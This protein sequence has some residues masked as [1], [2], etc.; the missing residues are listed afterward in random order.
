MGD[1]EHDLLQ[2]PLIGVRTAG[3]QAQ[4]RT[5]PGVLADLG[6]DDLV[7]FSGLQRHQEQAWHAFLVQLAAIALHEADAPPGALSEAKWR[8]LLLGLTGG[9]HEPWSLVVGDLAQPALL[10]PPV[11]G[12][13]LASFRWTT[14]CPDSLDILVTAKNHDV[15]AERMA[16]PEPQHWLYALVSL[17]TMQGFLGAG[18]YGIARMNGGFASRPSVG[19]APTLAWGPRFRRDVTVLR[20]G[21]AEIAQEYGYSQH[22]GHALLW[23]EPWDG[24]QALPLAA[25][26]PFFV[27]ICRRVRLIRA[28]ERIVARAAGSSVARLAASEAKGNTGDPWTPV[29]KSEGKALSVGAAGF[30]YQRVQELLFGGEYREGIAQ[31]LDPQ[32]GEEPLFLAAVLARSQ[33]KTLGLHS[34]Q[35]PIPAHVRPRLGRPAERERLSLLARQRI[36]VVAT[37][38]KKV[39]RPSLLVLFQ[40]HAGDLKMSDERPQPW[41]RRF[42]AAVDAVFF[43]RLWQDVDEDPE[44]A[45]RRWAQLVCEFAQAE[46][47]AAI[48]SA[49]LSTANRLRAVALAEGRFFGARY[50]HFPQLRPQEN[51]GGA[52]HEPAR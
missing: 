6:T 44:A 31:R 39:L 24:T 22:G 26:D 45:D 2:E 17:Q 21:R 42:D 18:N 12:G 50:R 48:R 9:R 13:T 19:F 28:S 40:G 3:G 52:R 8:A 43:D 11:A 36:D 5:L 27:E 33:G 7:G 35:L 1:A 20:E 34:R 4:P 47:E 14:A 51:E 29:E 41:L 37:A 38:A 16:R 46:L 23:L 25:C 32:D 30:S 49:P 15:K 10:Q